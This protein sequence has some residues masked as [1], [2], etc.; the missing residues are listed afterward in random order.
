[1]VSFI[2]GYNKH[3]ELAKMLDQAGLISRAQIR[4]VEKQAKKTGRDFV[5]LLLQEYQRI[6]DPLLGMI[7]QAFD[8][9][10]V[11]L[12]EQIIATAVLQLLPKEIAE[13]HSVIIFKK[14]QN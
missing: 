13:K 3:L 9:P 5:D 1:M 11:R 14:N 12:R 6:E 2:R 8:V 4:E 10:T 7:G